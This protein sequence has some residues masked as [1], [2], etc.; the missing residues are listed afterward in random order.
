MG[1][2]VIV[3]PTLKTNVRGNE[4]AGREGEWDHS[5][6]RRYSIVVST[7]QITGLRHPRPQNIHRRWGEPDVSPS[8]ADAESLS[9]VLAW[10]CGGG[11]TDETC[12]GVSSRSAVA[13]PPEL[14]SGDSDAR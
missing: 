2:K 5:P 6:L 11:D 14:E 1:V 8:V 9:V 10:F 13:T 7:T 3:E 12:G 4:L